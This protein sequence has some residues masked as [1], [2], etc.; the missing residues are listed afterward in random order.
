M[1]SGPVFDGGSLPRLLYFA[2]TP[3]EDHMAY[4]TLYRVLDVYPKNKLMIIEGNVASIPTRRIAGVTYHQFK[5]VWARLLYTRLHRYLSPLTTFYAPLRADALERLVRNFRPEAVMT[6]VWNYAWGTAAA[7]AERAGLPLHLIVHDD[8]RTG[9]A[10]FERRLVDRRLRHWY[11]KA[12]SRLCVSPYMVEEYRR[13]YEASGDV[14]YPSRSADAAVFAE[15]P[16]RLGRACEPFTVAFAG[17]IPQEYARALQRMATALRRNG[18]RLLVYGEA[19]PEITSAIC[20]EPNIEWR[21]RVDSSRELIRQCRAEAHTMY[22]PMSYREQDRPNAEVSFPSKLADC[23]AV[24]LPL[25]VDGP[26][27]CSAVRWAREN[28]GVA[29]V[30][31]DESVDALAAVVARLLEDSAHRLQLAKQAIRRGQ[32]YFGFNRAVSI[33]YSKL[34]G[35]RQSTESLHYDDARGLSRARSRR[36]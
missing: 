21:G 13:R 28:P 6:M 26:E 11:P 8:W 22:V 25:I 10:R 33:L 9:G 31:N 34:S 17:R 27:Y 12:A 35:S 23:T 5:L 19:P 18:G 30:I 1:R 4:S 20:Q 3:I 29:E 7:Y 32:Q 14:L 24:G 15:P 36:R 2:D 16:D